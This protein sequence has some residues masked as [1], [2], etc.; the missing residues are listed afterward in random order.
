MA[1][2]AGLEAGLLAGQAGALTPTCRRRAEVAK[3]V[4]TTRARQGRRAVGLGVVRPGR[5]AKDLQE[6]AVKKWVLYFGLGLSLLALSGCLFPF[7]HVAESPTG[8]LAVILDEEGNY[9]PFPVGGAVWLLGQQGELVRSVLELGETEAAGGLV[10]SPSGTEML[11]TILEL[12]E[13]FFFPHRWRIVRLPLAGEPEVIRQAEFPLSSPRYDQTGSAVFYL[14]SPG[15]TPELHRLDL[16]S[17]EDRV[18]ASDVLSF[19]P[20]GAELWLV[21]PQGR[22]EDAKGESVASFHCGEEDCRI[23][24]FLWPQLFLDIS[25][26]GDFLALVVADQPGLTSPHVDPVTSL[27]LL[28]IVQSSAQRIATPAVSPVFSPDGE[29]LA[30]VAGSPGREQQ[31]FIYELESS[32]VTGLP[33]SEGAFWVRWTQGGLLIAVEEEEGVFRLRR[34][35]GT[36]WQSL[37]AREPG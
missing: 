34:W 16:S 33:G 10:W 21:R 29:R 7:N 22:I 5:L 6:G 9:N 17:G 24:L 36:G 15:E 28:D 26:R 11:V 4:P 2:G 1:G 32:Q 12:D 19:L 8:E 13:E 14:A 31:V 35:D 37:L 18:L 30:F 20:V 27:Y 3:T 25:P 23:F